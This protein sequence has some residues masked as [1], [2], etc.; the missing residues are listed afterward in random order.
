MSL[1]LPKSRVCTAGGTSEIFDINLGVQQ[2]SMLSPLLFVV[3]LEEVT[4]E[5]WQGLVKDLNYADDLVLT[6]ESK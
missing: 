3:V 2:G 6:C 1:R 4:R 5:A